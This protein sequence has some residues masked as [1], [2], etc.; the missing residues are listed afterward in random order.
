MAHIVERVIAKTNKYLD[1]RI[2]F[3]F[4]ISKGHSWSSGDEL[5]KD[6]ILL[7][8]NYPSDSFNIS[9]INWINKII[10]IITIIKEK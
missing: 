5:Y 6:K 7:W 9:M 2:F 4:F 10:T 1:I 8:F 3:W